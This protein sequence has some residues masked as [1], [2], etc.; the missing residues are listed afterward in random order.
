MALDGRIGRIYYLINSKSNELPQSL[1]CL[2][3]LHPALY[4]ALFCRIN[5]NQLT[6]N[7]ILAYNLSTKNKLTTS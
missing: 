3:F 4:R 5:G 2:C 6:R 7:F 1:G